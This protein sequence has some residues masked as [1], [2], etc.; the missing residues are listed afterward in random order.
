MA[1]PKSTYYSP[2]GTETGLA[3]V[4]RLR[5]PRGYAQMAARDLAAQRKQKA[6]EEQAKLDALTSLKGKDVGRFHKNVYEKEL[7]SL[8]GRAN[9]LSAFELNREVEQLGIRAGST[10]KVEDAYDEDIKWSQTKDLPLKQEVWRADYTERFYLDPSMET[11]NQWAQERPRP[12]FFLNEDGGSKYVDANKASKIVINDHFN[13]YI[14]ETEWER[15]GWDQAPVG[16][17]SDLVARNTKVQAFSKV[18]GD[19][20]VIKGPEELI[21]Q[22]VLDPFVEN[23]WTNRVLTDRARELIANEKGIAPEDVASYEISPYYKAVALQ[24]QLVPYV[25]G[26]LSERGATIQVRPFVAYDQGRGDKEYNTGLDLWIRQ[27]SQGSLA[28]ARWPAGGKFGQTNELVVPFFDDPTTGG[29]APG[30]ISIL[31]SP[32]EVRKNFQTQDWF[33]G[34]T[35]DQKRAI[36]LQTVAA[37]RNLGQDA[38]VLYTFVSREEVTE[39]DPLTGTKTK[40]YDYNVRVINPEEA[41]RSTLSKIYLAGKRS[42]GAHYHVVVG[43][44]GMQQTGD[45]YE[46]APQGPFQFEE[47]EEPTTIKPGM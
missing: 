36:I 41:D 22:R 30:S 18:E 45:P 14:N 25:N 28:A 3:T 27:L 34:L 26:V 24:E 47:P 44:K 29:R 1:D 17:V 42:S 8:F 23:E 33:R 12:T 37:G 39:E 32:E 9:N 40:K 15:T 35:D 6:A 4:V 21:Q 10:M 11:A 20:I 7:N 2:T 16:W 43:E 13:E 19:E 5:A 46:Q 31:A 38:K